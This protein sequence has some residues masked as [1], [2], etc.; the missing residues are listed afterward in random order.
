ME[1]QQRNESLEDENVQLITALR[2]LC[3]D[4]RLAGNVPPSVLE[5][6]AKVSLIAIERA[7][8]TDGTIH[9]TPLIK[10]DLATK[11]PGHR[12]AFRAIL[13]P[14]SSQAE[15]MLGRRLRQLE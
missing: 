3:A 7:R 8:K 10:L 6:V 9:S 12:A 4:S 5:V 13:I 2:T 1:S 15:E 11:D 14:L